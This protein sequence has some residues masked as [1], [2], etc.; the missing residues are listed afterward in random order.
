MSQFSHSKYCVE[1][2]GKVT[3][4]QFVYVSKLVKFDG[5]FFESSSTEKEKSCSVCGLVH[6]FSSG[7]MNR[8]KTLGDIIK[9]IRQ[10]PAFYNLD[11]EDRVEMLRKTRKYW[12]EHYKEIDREQDVKDLLNFILKNID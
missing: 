3:L 8:K 6:N 1:C 9:S 11:H 12:N 7:H 2:R 4:D 10:D 5:H